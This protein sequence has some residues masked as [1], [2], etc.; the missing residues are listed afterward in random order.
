MCKVGASENKIA[1]RYKN[2]VEIT[3]FRV[4]IENPADMGATTH[5]SKTITHSTEPTSQA[6]QQPHIRTDV[7]TTVADVAVEEEKG[8]DPVPLTQ[9]QKISIATLYLKVYETEVHGLH[10]KFN[11]Y[12]YKNV[13]YS[14]VEV[15]ET[16]GEDNIFYLNG[17][18]ENYEQLFFGWKLWPP[19]ECRSKTFFD[20]LVRKECLKRRNEFPLAC[21][22]HLNFSHD[23]F[24]NEMYL[25][26]DEL[27]GRLDET[28]SW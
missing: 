4:R 16:I 2:K 1:Q 22:E 18:Y 12:M 6:P 14:M 17:L 20:D 28:G 27:L 3:T 15:L 5:A 19:K 26:L 24:G 11:N 7:V 23:M 25:G 21:V 10:K 8:M 13:Q 9:E